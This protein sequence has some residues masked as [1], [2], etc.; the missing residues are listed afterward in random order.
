V[1]TEITVQFSQKKKKSL[2]KTLKSKQK[3]KQQGWPLDISRHLDKVVAS[4]LFYAFCLMCIQQLSNQ[5]AAFLYILFSLDSLLF[6][7]ILLIVFFTHAAD[8]YRYA[9]PD[10]EILC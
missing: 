9:S 8:S 10:K 2:Y 6:V 4:V 7:F 1:V 3:L 5:P